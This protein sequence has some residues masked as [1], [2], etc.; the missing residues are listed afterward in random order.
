MSLATET[1]TGG[2]QSARPDDLAHI[3]QALDVLQHEARTF[4]R[5]DLKQKIALLREA[6]KH[7]A[8][9]AEQWAEQGHRAKGLP[10]D[11]AEEWLVG[12]LPTMRNLRL[13]ADTLERLDAG[14]PSVAPDRVRRRSDG[15]T[16]VDVFPTGALDAALFR[17]FEAVHVMQDGLTEEQVIAGAGRFYRQG[18]PEGGVSLILGAGNVSSIPAMDALSKMFA[19]GR[20]C[21][22]KVNPVNEWVGPILEAALSPFID[23]GFLRV[24]YGGRSVGEY[25]VQHAAVTDVHITGSNQTH[26]AIV[27][28]PPGAERERRRSANEPLLVKPITSELG[29]VGPVCVVP[30]EYSRRQ[31]TFMARN[32]AAM[33]TNNASFNC[34]AAKVLITSRGWPQREAF[35]RQLTAALSETPTRR[36]YYPGAFDRYDTLTLGQDRVR[37]IGVAGDGRLPWTIIEDVDCRASDAVQFSVEPFCAVI[38]ETRLDPVDPVEFLHA[39]TGFMNDTLWGSLNATVM[40]HPALERSVPVREQLERTVDDLRYGT[41]AINHWPGVSYG[42]TSPAWGGH[43]S[44]TLVNVQSGIGWVHNTYLLEGVEKVVFRGPLEVAPKPV[45]FANHRRAASLGRKMVSFERA[46]AW[47]KLPG[48]LPDALT[49]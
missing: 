39:A 19:E 46:P 45:W 1:L 34:N 4:A 36:A 18:T 38:T 3:D 15:R 14:R 28:G 24:V 5:L 31:L 26:D 47:W 2:V 25:L 13:L 7:T 43:P 48:L 30:A 12:P 8:D 17:G 20:V 37:K 29:N 10:Y 33:I 49:G 6:M 27:W 44:S 11:H 21:M 41:V 23:R 35:L 40:I 9:V 32:V 42:A 16:E 22:V